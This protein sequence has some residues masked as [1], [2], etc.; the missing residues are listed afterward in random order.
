M[1]AKAPRRSDK[2]AK[3]RTDRFLRRLGRLVLSVFFREIQTIG[4]AKIPADGPVMIVS[5]HVNSLIDGILV[6][7]FLP[8]MPRL[9]AASTVWNYLP[10]RPFLSAAGVIPLYRSHEVGI[11]VARHQDT[12]DRT[13]DLLSQGGVLALFPEGMSHSSPHLLPMQSGAARIALN[14]AATQELTIVPV[15]LV[16]D[17]KHR[18]RSRALMQVGD[19]IPVPRQQPP[20]DNRARRQAVRALSG[21]IQIGLAAVT[22]NFG[23]WEDAQLVGRAAELWEQ[24][25]PQMP[26]LPDIA[27]S[28]ELRREF[29]E[30]YDW[31]QQHYPQKTAR[32]R[33]TFST[34]HNLLFAAGL[35]DA[36][37]GAA[38]PFVPAVRFLLRSVFALLVGLPVSA[39]GM[40][41]N[42]VPIRIARLIARGKD[43]DKMATWSLLSSVIVFPAAWLIEA[44]LAGLASA[45]WIGDGWGWTGFAVILIAAPIAGRSALRFHDV[46]RNFFHEARGWFILRTRRDLA[47]SLGAIR[48]RALNGLRDLVE[49]YETEA[50]ELRPPAAQVLRKDD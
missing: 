8:R 48:Q 41:L 6:T 12:F 36:Q 13:G 15:G 19:P 9:L 45:R 10:L 29:S 30:G 17:A 5:N 44:I 28:V 32:L 20:D 27:D 24:Q 7:S 39:V 2:P 1:T 49:I 31:M 35:R 47:Q 16:Y 34:Y 33:Q 42:W 4:T 21:Q 25:E 14:A 46:Q 23:S 37:V 40:V 22:L 11:S 50:L 26:T 38:Y 43:L 3:S 18:F